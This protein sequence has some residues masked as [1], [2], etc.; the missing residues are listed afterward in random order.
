MRNEIYEDWTLCLC[1]KGLNATDKSFGCKDEK[2]LS[3]FACAF[4][5][6]SYSRSFFSLKSNDRCCGLVLL[7]YVLLIFIL[8]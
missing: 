8:L 5:L 3:K 6:L 1:F 4:V 7:H 2:Y